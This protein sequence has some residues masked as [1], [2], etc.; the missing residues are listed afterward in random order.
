[1]FPAHNTTSAQVPVQYASPQAQQGI[2]SFGPGSY[3][4]AY[5]VPNLYT[6]QVSALPQAFH[7]MT[8]QDH[9]WKMDIGASSHLADNIGLPDPKDSS[10]L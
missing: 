7:T 10:P 8:P 2:N 9:F 5:S 4:Y 1:Q 3:S 6:P